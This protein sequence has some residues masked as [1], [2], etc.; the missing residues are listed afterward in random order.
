MNTDSNTQDNNED[1]KYRYVETDQVEEGCWVRWANKEWLRAERS[2]PAD[3]YS[4]ITLGQDRLNIHNLATLGVKFYRRIEAPE[5]WEFCKL[6]ETDVYWSATAGFAIK[7][8]SSDYPVFPVRPIPETEPPLPLVIECEYRQKDLNEWS[9][10]IVTLDRLADDG[11]R[12][13]VV[14]TQIVEP[15]TESTS[16]PQ[17]L[18]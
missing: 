7:Y 2:F 10:F 11:K 4:W 3:C 17:P 16:P 1:N 15:K 12:F 6:E 13:K 18:T 8:G 5:G 14:A 9:L